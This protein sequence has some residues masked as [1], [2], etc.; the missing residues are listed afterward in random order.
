MA[1]PSPA[2]AQIPGGYAVERMVS[3]VWWIAMM[4]CLLA[5]V[6]SAGA[7]GV[8]EY[9]KKQRGS[10]TA[11]SVFVISLGSCVLV[12]GAGALVSQI[13]GLSLSHLPRP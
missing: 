6:C 13:A 5:I 8:C 11:V 2:A 9:R 7:F 10:N 12:G 4:M 3:W 1:W